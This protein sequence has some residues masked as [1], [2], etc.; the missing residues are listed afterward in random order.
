MDFEEFRDDIITQLGGGMV[1][2]ELDDTEIELAFKK[3]KRTFQQKGH[4]SYR[5]QFFRL[6]VTSCKMSYKLPTEVDT[7][8]RVIQ[9]SMG[10]NISDEFSMVAYNQ[11]FGSTSNNQIGDWLS[12]E[13][14]LQQIERWGRYNV[15]EIPFDYDPFRKTISFLKA[16]RGKNTVWLIEL[17]TNLTDE[18]YMDILW[19]QEWA[20]AEAKQMLGNA[21]RKFSQLSGPN[22][23]VSLDGGSLIQESKQEKEQLLDDILNGVDGSVDYYEIVF[24]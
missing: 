18:E 16:P 14:T 8:V 23:V 12:Y 13:F 15:K 7:V 10:F 11:M 1:D 4:N 17:Y 3:A 22:G 19:V 2:V 5:R 9:P 20:M 24:G 6:P 21:Y